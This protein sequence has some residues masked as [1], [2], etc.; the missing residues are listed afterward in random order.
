MFAQTLKIQKS[1]PQS[2]TSQF[3]DGE[4]SAKGVK[5]PYSYLY[6]AAQSHYECKFTE[7]LVCFFLL[8]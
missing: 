1:P 4:K 5:T 3:S 7:W 8:E 2:P 6:T